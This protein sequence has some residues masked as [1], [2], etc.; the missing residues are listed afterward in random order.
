ME[1][2]IES[3][4]QGAK[5]AKGLAVIIDVFRAC[6]TAAY[7]FNNGAEKII[8]VNS[9][10]QALELKKKYGNCI[11]IGEQ[12]GIQIPTFDYG[13]SPS[14][15]DSLDFSGKVVVM[16]TTNG[17]EGV[18]NASHADTIL[19]AGFLNAKATVDYIMQQQPKIVTL[20][21]MGSSGENC[22]EDDECAYYLKE[23]LQQKVPDFDL[24]KER[25]RIS[26]TAWKFFDLQNTDFPEQ[27]FYYTMT[28]NRFSFIM[29]VQQK[30]E[31]IE[32]IAVDF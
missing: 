21:A 9:E 24:L 13:N 5:R 4:V 11:T 32:I 17:T 3:L 16:K 31:Q 10:A 19:I 30:N 27:D 1:I 7:L 8:P 23:S 25:I 20:V 29:K 15:I 12:K 2:I 14:K 6:S 22:L 28:L 18:L 26:K